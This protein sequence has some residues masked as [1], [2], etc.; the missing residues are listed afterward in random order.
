MLVHE[1]PS[2][3]VSAVDTG[4]V[5][6]GAPMRMGATAR[7]QH[8]SPGRHPNTESWPAGQ[9]TT[10]SAFKPQVC[11]PCRQRFAKDMLA[12]L[13]QGWACAD[14]GLCQTTDGRVRLLFPGA[15][16]SSHC[17]PCL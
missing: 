14:G 3:A 5:P 10:T 12:I 1:T 6:H 17:C 16:H 8:L 7:C 15:L 11:G 9:I 2:G 4:R 13:L